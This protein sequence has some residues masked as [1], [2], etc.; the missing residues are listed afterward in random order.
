MD[1]ISGIQYRSSQA[2]ADPL[3]LGV[4]FSFIVKES[5]SKRASE[6]SFLP[7]QSPRVRFSALQ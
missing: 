4:T 2:T 5:N 6:V 1:R 3:S 7:I